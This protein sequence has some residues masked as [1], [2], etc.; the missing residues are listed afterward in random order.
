VIVLQVGAVRHTLPASMPDEREALGGV[1]RAGRTA[2]A[3]MRRLLGALRREDDD[4][5]L[6]PEPGLDYLTPLL[7][8][9]RRAGLRVDLQVEGD[10]TPLPRTLD[11]SAY[12]VVQEGLTNAL[13][14]A[15]A[16]RADVVVR[17]R[18]SE[19]EVAVGDDGRGLARGNGHRQGHGLV[20][21]A[22][23]VKIYG[24]QMSASSRPEGGFVLNARFPLETDADT[25]GR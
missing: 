3:E 7:D 25:D 18:P 16:S 4:V 1:E 22:E 5:E 13:K 6:S 2:L 14:H 9:V 20:G 19:L 21:I 12:R 23:R 24:G 11:M 17:Y 8:Q 10:P 15:R